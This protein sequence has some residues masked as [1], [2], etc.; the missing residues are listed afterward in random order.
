MIE[1]L[2]ARA[3]LTAAYPGWK[4]FLSKVQKTSRLF[5]GAYINGGAKLLMMLADNGE[6]RVL[7]AEEQAAIMGNAAWVDHDNLCHGYV[8]P[9]AKLYSKTLEWLV[10]MACRSRLRGGAGL[11][12]CLPSLLAASRAAPGP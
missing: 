5:D 7:T 6:L 8:G 12:C 4:V 3:A 1:R 10:I 9:L 11:P 2:A